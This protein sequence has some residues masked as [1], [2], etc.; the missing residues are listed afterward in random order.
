MNMLM[1]TPDNCTQKL[2]LIDTI[3]RLGVAYHF[4]DEIKTSIQNIFDESMFQQNHNKQNLYVVALRFRLV[5]QQGHY[6][7]AGT[8]FFS[9][10]SFFSCDFFNI[11]LF[12]FFFF[13]LKK[14]IKKK[15]IKLK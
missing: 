5:R 10:T 2:V 4:H 3:Q 9:L 15:K 12:Q 13:S 8:Y 6:I 7:S 1:E 14:Q 11:S